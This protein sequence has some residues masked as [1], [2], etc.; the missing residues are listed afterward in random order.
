MKKQILAVIPARGGSK[1]IPRKNIK[2]FCGKPIIAYPIS[3]IVKSG[4]FDEVM[5]STDDA[6]IAKI[7]EK[8]GANVPFMRSSAT[9]DD[10]ATTIDVLNEVLSE[11]EKR[12][13]HFDS[14]C[15]V[16]PC[17]PLISSFKLIEANNVFQANNEISV[18]FSAIQYSYPIQRSFRIVDS[19]VE[20][21]YPEKF[22]SRT[23]DLEPI[24]HDAGQFYFLSEA[25]I[26][27]REILFAEYSCPYLI[28]ELE[29]Q[30]IDTES[31]WKITE[32]K[33]KLMNE[34]KE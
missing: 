29:A 34:V 32:L 8:Y 7:A 1:R 5:V 27:N 26:K 21:L 22:G 9:S 30:D 14:I 20:M 16:Y 13:R 19:K 3:E 28:S 33:Y 18:V 25:V 10:Y 11:Y 24:Y 6:E 31:D 17:S 12:G 15:C 2:L 23:Q 4:I